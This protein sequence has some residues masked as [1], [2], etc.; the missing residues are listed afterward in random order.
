MLSHP[1][2]IPTPCAT[3]NKAFESD[4]R[5]NAL[6]NENVPTD[7]VCQSCY[8]KEYNDYLLSRG[9]EM[10]MLEAMMGGM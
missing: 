10:P 5:Y 7:S 9:A 3:C 1:R 6:S 4:F 2:T 8:E